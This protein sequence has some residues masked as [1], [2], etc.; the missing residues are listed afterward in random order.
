MVAA[1]AAGEAAAVDRAV[2]SGVV[3]V[4]VAVFVVGRVAAQVGAWVVSTAVRAVVPV[5]LVVAIAVA[6]GA[7]IVVVMAV[8]RVGVSVRGTETGAAAG[9]ARAS[10]A[11]VAR[12]GVAGTDGVVPAGSVMAGVCPAGAVA[13]AGVAGVLVPRL[14]WLLEWQSV[15]RLAHAPVAIIL[16]DVPRLADMLFRRDIMPPRVIMGTTE[17]SRLIP[18]G[19]EAGTSPINYSVTK[20]AAL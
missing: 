4:E 12:G 11:G 20:S 15:M 3:Q 9:V 8:A 16:R 6:T 5:V 18:G 1:L 14:A 19:I 10:L 13:G 17:A 7:G 2:A